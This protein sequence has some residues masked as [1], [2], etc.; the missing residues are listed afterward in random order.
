[1]RFGGAR[2]LSSV[3]AAMTLCIA[4]PAY[5]SG[6]QQA[7]SPTVDFDERE[8]SPDE[9]QVARGGD[10]MD[11]GK[12]DEAILLFD[13]VLDRSPRN[14][15]AL[16]NRALAY[17]W[18]NRL[19]EAERD[20][21]A[22]EAAIPG[23]AVL[24]RIRAVIAD[25]RSDDATV[26]AE[27]TKTLAIEPENVMALRFRAN[28][29]QRNKRETDAL[30]DADTYIKA[31]SDDPDAY[32]F[33]ANLLIRQQ[34]RSA[35]FD[36]AGRLKEQFPDNAYAVAAA[37]RIFDQL[38]ERD[39][40]LQLITE[41]IIIDPEHYYYHSLRAGMR[42]WDDLAGRKADLETANALDPN[43]L[44]TITQLGVVEFK[45]RHWSNAVLYFTKVLDRE[46]QDYGVRAYRAM[47]FLNAGDQ[48]RATS[49]FD[50]A[51]LA[52]S[53]SDDFSLICW[54]LGREG[55]ALDWAVKACDK[56]VELKVRESAYRS[57]RGLVRLRLG[58]LAAAL[59]DYDAAVEADDRLASNYYG[60]A[61]VRQRTGDIEGANADRVRALAI[62]PT[63]AETFE[64]YGLAAVQ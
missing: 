42:R 20:L 14:G 32:V 44:N 49:D 6:A 24:H 30:A 1:M 16:A 62:D 63:I 55:Q 47:A 48:T 38:G 17:G 57:N 18:T 11:Q 29:Y 7:D 60:R 3:A 54:A 27:T 37:A 41:A 4:A 58:Q 46:T 61:V 33:K 13:Q 22:A 45:L 59:E 36:Q 56:A 43:N 40:A 5:G 23:A 19:E 2:K 51:M 25:R 53:G 28:T 50:E 26:I 21:R 9:A 35:A 12:Y 31:H 64:E 52:A 34:K 10:L 39:K 8:L 15:N